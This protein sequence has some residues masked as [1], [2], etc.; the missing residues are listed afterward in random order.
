MSKRGR[1]RA[2]DRE[3]ALRQAMALFWAKGYENTSM[4]EL[5]AATGLKPPSLYAAFGSKEDLFKAAIELY[6]RTTGS[7]IWEHLD[8]APTAREAIK[9]LLTASAEA[10][11]R[12]GVPHGCM[13]VLAAPQCESPHPTVLQELQQLRAGNASAIQERLQR[14]IAEGE[15]SDQTDCASVACYYATLQHGLS[16]QARDGASRK[17]LLTVVDCAMAA[18]DQLTA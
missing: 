7:G 13:I 3:E 12:D 11:T 9:R 15:I 8:N 17:Q 6:K 4:A 18:W 1:P 2:F 5:T 14:A 10:F 16:I